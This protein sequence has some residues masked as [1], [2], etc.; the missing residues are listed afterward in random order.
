MSD[1]LT[2]VAFFLIIEGLVYALAPRLLVRMAK[3]LPDIPEGQLRLSGLV[4]IAFG[5][6]L[7]WLLRG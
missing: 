3:L 4:A 1:F 6:A 2:G 7:V 5:V